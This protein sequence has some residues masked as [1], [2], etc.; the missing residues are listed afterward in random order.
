MTIGLI[1]GGN[2]AR[3]LI[4]GLLRNGLSPDGLVVSDPNPAIR[5]ALERDFG[6]VA[7][8]DNERLARTA[9]T[10]ILAVKPQ[11]LPTITAQIAAVLAG[12]STLVISIAAGISTTALSK[13]LGTAIVVRTMPNTP[14][15]VSAGMTV[16]FA[17]ASV[18]APERARAETIMKAVGETMWV[19]EEDLMDAVTAVSGSGPAYFFLVMEALEQ[20]AITAGLKAETARK[21]VSQTALGAALMTLARDPATLRL[22]VT[23]PGG[24]TERAIGVLED[25]G[26]R[27]SFAKAIS[28]ASARSRELSDLYR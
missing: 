16:L 23:S 1:G 9:E 26:L 18:H 12:R 3:S 7:H 2:M 4:G 14:A 22:Q 17:P 11:T 20:A 27:A 21:L 15:L 24:T 10:L 13:W 5:A 19:D 8:A 28:A 25:A 6:V